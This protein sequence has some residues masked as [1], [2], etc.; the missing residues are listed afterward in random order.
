[1]RQIRHNGAVRSGSAFGGGIAKVLDG[2]IFD[3][4]ALRV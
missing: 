3:C 2:G 1:L 4:R